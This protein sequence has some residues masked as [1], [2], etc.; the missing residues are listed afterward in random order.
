MKLTLLFIA[1]CF[2]AAEAYVFKDESERELDLS[3]REIEDLE[4]R[5]HAKI[6]ACEKQV[7]EPYKPQVKEVKAC[8]KALG[9]T[10]AN[11][12]ECFDEFLGLEKMNIKAAMKACMKA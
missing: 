1:V 4:M 2:V 8:V 9:K 5:D 7:L 6:K 10:K 11:K 12:I 3:L